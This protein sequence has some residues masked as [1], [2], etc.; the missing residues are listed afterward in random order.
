MSIYTLLWEASGGSGYNNLIFV[1]IYYYIGVP[2][3]PGIHPAQAV[4]SG[5]YRCQLLYGKLGGLPD[6]ERFESGSDWSRRRYLYAG[7]ELRE[8]G[9]SRWAIS[10]LLGRSDGFVF[11]FFVGLKSLFAYKQNFAYFCWWMLYVIRV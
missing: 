1:V 3:L 11:H 8:G 4:F 2:T 9:L 5:L 10:R 6:F 7:T